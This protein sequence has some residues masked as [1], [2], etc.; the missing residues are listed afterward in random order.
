MLYY[1]VY[2]PRVYRDE[3]VNKVIEK[4][5]CLFVVKEKGVKGDHPHC[6]FIINSELSRD[7]LRKQ[8]VRIENDVKLWSVKKITDK[9]NTV[10]YMTKEDAHE[11]LLNNLSQDIDTYKGEGEKNREKAE[12]FSN[13]V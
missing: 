11:I 4:Y 1:V 10:N 3:I 2:S 5:V 6:N 12:L 9:S 13:K 8:L 7:A